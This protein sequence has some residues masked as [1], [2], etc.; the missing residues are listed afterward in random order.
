MVVGSAKPMPV[1]INGPTVVGLFPLVPQQAANA[2]SDLSESLGDFQFHL[3]AAEPCLRKSGVTVL[4]RYDSVLTI[5][6]GDLSLTFRPKADEISY[7]FVEPGHEAR[8]EHS[9]L[10]RSELA[11]IADQ[12][13]AKDLRP[14]GAA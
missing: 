3:R 14:C 6:D 13:F 5:V 4:E 8:V 9:I 10:T 2:D 1:L 7:Y 12:Y 11:D